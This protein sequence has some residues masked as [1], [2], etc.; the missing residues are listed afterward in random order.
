V[1]DS[2]WGIVGRHLRT[3]AFLVALALIAAASPPTDGHRAGATVASAERE[4]DHEIDAA[5]YRHE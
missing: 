2:I 4:P 1:A 3:L 5:G